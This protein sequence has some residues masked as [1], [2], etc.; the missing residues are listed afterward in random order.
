MARKPKA[1]EEPKGETVKALKGFDHEFKCRGFQ[2]EVGKTYE[3][4]GAVVM[5]ESG[6]H[7]IEGHPF[8]VWEY[9]PPA[10]EG[11]L[12]RY[13]EV[14]CSGAIRREESDRGDS[15]ICAASIAIVRTR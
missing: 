12:A 15:K 2:F 9:Y 3:H 6:F 11:G 5:C 1:K 4:A 10:N 13:A 14:Q 7:A 8:E